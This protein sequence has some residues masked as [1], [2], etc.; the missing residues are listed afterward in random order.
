MLAVFNGL[1]PAALETL[2][3]T[4]LQGIFVTDHRLNIQG[5]NRWMEIHSG[6]PAHQV[7]G[8]NLLQLY[9]SLGE[10][11]Q[12]SL[13]Q[14]ALR[15][16]V[17]VLAQRFHHYLLPFLPVGTDAFAYMRQTARIMPLRD[18]DRV[19]GTITFIEDVTERALRDA[20]I[21]KYLIELKT[22][23]DR[24]QKYLD[25][26]GVMFLILDDAGNVTRVNRKTCD[27]LG[28]EEGEILG[29]NWFDHFLPA[30]VKDEVRLIFQGLMAGDLGR[31][32]YAE[33]AVLTKGGGQRLIAWQN[34]VLKDE[35]GRITGAL[36][37]G[38]DITDRKAMEAALA[39]E[40]KIT[41][42]LAELS[43]ILLT[44]TTIEEI[45][46]VVLSHARQLTD[47]SLGFVGYIDLQTGFLVCP[48][49][50]TEVWDECR[51]TDKSIVFKEFRGLFG[52]VL[53]HKQPL[54]TNQPD[55]DPRSTG[56][57]AGHLPI[58]RFL[59]VP[60]LL[61]SQL[62]GQIA[63]ANAPRDYTEADQEVL[64][65]L[66]VVYS[67]AVSRLRLE[68]ELL[69][70]AVRDQLTGLFNRR[71]FLT[72]A[73]QAL[74]EARRSQ[75]G[76]WLLFADLDG[77]KEINDTL[78]HAA[79]DEALRHTA[80]ILQETYRDADIIGRLGGDEFALLALQSDASTGEFLKNRLLEQIDHFNAEVNLPYR[81]SLSIGLA[82]F[83]S[84]DPGSLDEF[85]SRA[86]LAMYA[87]KQSKGNPRRTAEEPAE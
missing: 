75:S 37:S 85:M 34:T 22:T 58:H 81:I 40:A 5:W 1:G 79:G 83:D 60:A 78:G 68:E 10:R 20:E 54:L 61:Q 8:K 2:G 36:S 30:G 71:G 35:P 6:L 31:L 74:K 44:P 45:S 33:S 41:V 42:A 24:A 55:Q 70:L 15:G 11:R 32:Q 66:A 14:D 39:R 64:Q 62:V 67:M 25:V 86:D 65:R 47:S 28:W 59:G 16:Q 13:Y 82:F 23:R 46:V 50:A 21:R 53:Q 80:G 72:L 77:M 38:D 63:V 76:V 87:H 73:E 17:A 12:D 27:V 48:S 43:Q 18:Q 3:Q 7:V 69:S 49:M 19:I 57:P 29:K 84:Q 51:M 4:E 52:W 26:A 9:P 56:T